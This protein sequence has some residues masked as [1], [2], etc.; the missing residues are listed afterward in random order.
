M[1]LS[2]DLFQTILRDLLRFLLVY[3]IFLFGFAAGKDLI[4]IVL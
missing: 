4:S 3:I 1:T 2:P